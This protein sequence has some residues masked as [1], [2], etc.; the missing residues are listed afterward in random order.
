MINHTRSVP[1]WALC[2]RIWVLSQ[3]KTSLLSGAHLDAPEKYRRPQI[4]HVALA[5]SVTHP[6]ISRADITQL[7]L[8]QKSRVKAICAEIAHWDSQLWGGGLPTL[9]SQHHH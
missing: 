2:L 1:G 4:N 5:L 3:I 8:H 6:E 9:P 7:R